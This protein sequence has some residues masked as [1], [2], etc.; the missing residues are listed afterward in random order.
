MPHPIDHMRLSMAP[1][2]G[3]TRYIFRNAQAR[4]FGGFDVYYTPFLSP[5]LHH[6]FRHREIDDILPEH[7]AGLTVIPQLLT[8]VP[9]DFLWA[10]WE[11]AHLGYP[12]VNLNLGCPMGTV[13]KKCKGAGFLT[14][15]PRLETFLDEIYEKTPVDISI[16]T[17]LGWADPVEFEAILRLLECYPVKELIVHAR[18]REEFYEGEAHKDIYREILEDT[19]LPCAYNGDLFTPEEA[20]TMAEKAPGSTQLM[21]GRGMLANPAIARQIRGGAPMKRGELASFY[22]EIRDGYLAVMDNETHVL[23]KCKELWMYLGRSFPE[24]KKLIKALRKANRLREFD[25]AA[26]QLLQRLPE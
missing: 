12:E 22:N 1:M 13:A 11:C 17:R 23:F 19:F 6:H 21:F 24:E 16:K 2:E 18:V 26:G 7:N 4:V 5:N 3:I 8:N 20:L 15:L 10:A 9:D 14:D 25:E